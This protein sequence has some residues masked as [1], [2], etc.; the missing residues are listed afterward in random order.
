M[1]ILSV[2]KKNLLFLLAGISL[3][4]LSCKFDITNN[5][6]S[7]TITAPAI[8]TGTDGPVIAPTMSSSVTYSYLSIF[9]Y[10]VSGS[11]DSATKVSGSTSLIGQITPASD[12]TGS[13]QFTDLYA[14]T[15]KYYQYYIRYKTAHAYLYS[16]ASGTHQGTGTAGV[17]AITNSGS[18]PVQMTLDTS[19]YI[20][21]TDST[22]LTLPGTFSLMIGMNN[23][24]ST[25]LLPMTLDSANS[26]YTLAMRNVLPDSFLATAITTECLVGQTTAAVVKGTNDSTVIYTVYH[27]TQS[28]EAETIDSTSA[29]LD[30]FTVPKDVTVS[31]TVDFTP[32]SNN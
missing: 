32:S 31:G 1:P 20:L 16:A 14:D 4:T 13:V 11:S 9:R 5:T 26:K 24:V 21:S 27:W 28:L 19:Q 30:S 6:S 2:M 3:V 7:T 15:S 17:Q 23:G 8:S 22:N 12:Y 29:V 10:E 25:L 18:S